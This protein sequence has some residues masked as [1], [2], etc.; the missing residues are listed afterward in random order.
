MNMGNHDTRNAE[1]V[2][3]F[4]VI[5]LLPSISSTL[6]CTRLNGSSIVDHNKWLT[7]DVYPRVVVDCKSRG[8]T[9]VPKLDTSDVT[10]LD[11]SKNNI[12]TIYE[13]DFV[14]MTELRILVLASSFVVALYE[15]CFL[16]LTR[17]EQDN[18]TCSLRRT[19]RTAR[20]HVVWH[21][22]DVISDTVCATHTRTASIVSQ[23]YRKHHHRCRIRQSNSPRGARL[24]RR[25]VVEITAAMFDN[26][27]KSNIS[28]LSFRR[29]GDLTHIHP[30]AFTNLPNVRSLV[31]SC[32]AELPYQHAMTSLGTIMNTRVDTV[33]LDGSQ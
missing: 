19:P 16:K 13:K 9:R 33:V 4:I 6:Q 8:M 14:N 22:H 23:R 30:G 11:L 15:N 29:L 20:A 21:S 28:T 1:V 25:K 18:S 7:L 2:V 31:L 24:L 10:D 12:T 27:R 26:I 17:L 3:I 32:N 5:C